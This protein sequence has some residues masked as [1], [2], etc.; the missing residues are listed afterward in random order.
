MTYWSRSCHFLCFE[1]FWITVYAFRALGLPGRFFSIV[2]W[3]LFAAWRSRP[4]TGRSLWRKES[5]S[6]LAEDFR[7][8]FEPFT[9]QEYWSQW[10]TDNYPSSNIIREE[11]TH[12]YIYMYIF[13]Y[14]YIYLF[15]FIHMCNIYVYIYIYINLYIWSCVCACLYLKTT[16]QICKRAEPPEPHGVGL[17]LANRTRKNPGTRDIWPT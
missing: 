1:L 16:S 9:S 12:I 2:R 15:I 13:I 3:I 8:V 10:S 7:L 11:Y 5:S 17:I 6:K 14:I 4:V